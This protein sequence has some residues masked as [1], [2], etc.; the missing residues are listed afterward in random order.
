MVNMDD[1]REKDDPQVQAEDN[2]IAIGG[3]HIDGDASGNIT[4]GHGYTAE[5]VSVLL[6]QITTTFQP[7]PFDGRCPYKGLDVFEEEDAEL[8]FGRERLVDDLVSRVKESRAVFI[9]GP[10]GSGKSSL[11]RAGLIQALKEGAIK[12]LH[13]ER[14]MYETIKPGR[15]PTEALALAFSR[16]KSPEL[17]NYFREHVAETSILHE[18]AESVLSGRKYQRFVL[19]LDQFEEAFTQI[20]REEERVTFLNWLTHAAMVENG[21]VIVL[22]AMRSDFVSNCAT[23]PQLNSMFNQQSLQIG[24]MQSDELVRAIAQ[25]AL[26]VGLR[27]DPDLVAQIIND[28]HGEPGALPLMQFTMRDLFDSKQE[29]GGIIALTLEEYLQHGGIR[30]SLERHA[31]ASFATLDKHEQEIARSIFS[32]LIEIGRGAQDTSRTALFDE[33]IPANTNQ[34]D[35][36]AVVHKLADARLITTDEQAGKDTVMISH[37]KLIDAWPWLKK[38]VNENR[39]VI[40]L[41]NEIASDAKEWQ[42]HKRDPSYLY[43]GARLVNAREQLEARKLVLS[44]TAYEF[45]RAGV[46][47]QKRSQTAV[48]GSIAAVIVLLTAAVIIFASLTRVAQRESQIAL[49]RQLA[50]QAQAI[51]ATNNS[52]QMTAV[53][54]ATYSMNIFPSSEAA[55]VLLNRDLSAFPISRMTH[56]RD[57][58][59]IAFSPDGKQVVSGSWDNTARVWEA[60]TGREVARMTHDN[61]VVSVAFSPDGKYIVSGSWDKTARVWEMATGNEVARMTHDGA[62]VSVAFSPDGKHV[63]SGSRDNTARVWEVFTGREVARMTHDNLV[64]SV[65]FSP[66]GKYIVSGSWDK[67]ARVW[68][69]ATGN[70]VARVTHSDKVRSVAFS[71]DGKYVASGSEDRTVRVWKA[72]TGQETARLTHDHWVTSVA[73][74]PDGKYIVSGNLDN[75]SRVWETA[76]G[77]EIAR[78][79]HDDAVV[80]VDFSPDSTYVVSGSDDRTARVWEAATG[81]EIARMTH[82]G[83]VHSV[84][85]SQSGKYVVSG[86][87]DKTARVWEASE[88]KEVARVIHDSMVTSVA[89]SPDGN[90][91]VSGSGDDTSGKYVFSGSGGRTIRVWEAAT[92]IEI[93]HM[94]HDGPVTSVAF[95]PD[96]NYVVSGSWDWTARVWEVSTGQEIARMTYFRG[97]VSSVAFSPDGRYVISGSD[98]KTARVW[99]ALTGKEVGRMT[100]DGRVYRIA[101]SPDGRYVVSGGEDQ[102]ARVWEATTGKEIARMTHNNVVLSVA[103]SPDSKYVVSGSGDGTTR[104]WEATTGKAVA[105]VGDASNGWVWDVAFSPDGKYVVSEG[106]GTVRVWESSTGNVVARMIHDRVVNSVAF[107]RDG[108]YLISGSNDNTARVWETL[109][110]KEVARMAH[111]DFVTSVAF[112]PDGK[113]VVSGSGD[114]TARVWIWQPGDLIANACAHLPRNLTSAEWKQYVSDALSY[115]V[116]CPNLPIHPTV[117]ADIAQQT[118]SDSNDPNRVQTAINKV[119][120]FLKENSNSDNPVEDANQIVKDVIEEQ[121]SD[122]AAGNLRPSLSLLED[123]KKIGLEIEDALKLNNICWF[124]SIYGYATDVLEYC[125]QAVILAPENQNIRDSRGLARALT[126]NIEG[127][128][129]DFQYFIEHSTSNDLIQER[130]Q[131][132]ADLRAGKNP[133]TPEELEKLK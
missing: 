49:A 125:E 54:L 15:E 91:V 59:F 25:P 95:S 128:I 74:S 115:Q 90:Y 57:V 76:T 98:D 52:K 73:F 85:F 92:G 16:L 13:S 103:F 55:Q 53:L 83:V 129:S 66:D 45:V 4:I 100:H 41:Q 110:G 44:G 20:N 71:P 31:D 56:D 58:S 127:A 37:E 80:S 133:F 93:A 132:I 75:T 61:F 60:F 86:S 6:K 17:A 84:A 116:I 68:E 72:D 126:G 29:Q 119:S 62:V 114:K 108:K 39:E 67:T 112:S 124:G 40:A 77:K 8:F 113:Y 109:T 97:G 96:A 19:F 11:V 89:F 118:L 47:R 64:V 50:A 131:W 7:K 36:Q 94:T 70:E 130:Q 121:I 34:T 21:R 27:I 18:C 106:F 14:W 43:S 5:Q 46:A 82:D 33:L 32:G 122:L 104:V 10:S 99:E 26:R 1:E 30:K 28:M 105:R 81:R 9:I 123:A 65:A 79:T 38:L 22:F 12:R 107:S 78:M 102:T 23:Y 101:F 24:A 3:I 87:G 63:V 120:D 88:G 51:T 35:V 2:S 42:D 48:I 69:M 111:D 117:L